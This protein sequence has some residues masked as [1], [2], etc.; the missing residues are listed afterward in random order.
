MDGVADAGDG[1][2]VGDGDLLGARGGEAGGVATSEVVHDDSVGP[3]GL[4]GG[5]AVVGTLKM[6]P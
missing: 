2:V 3:V 4:D 5:V 1:A 6:Q